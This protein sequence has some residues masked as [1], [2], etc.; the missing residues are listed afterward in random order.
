M[1][2]KTSRL[3]LAKRHHAE[4]ARDTLIAEGLRVL[5]F[6]SAAWSDRQGR[7]PTPS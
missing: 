4:V 6:G 5:F 1:G 2:E 3:F 7:S